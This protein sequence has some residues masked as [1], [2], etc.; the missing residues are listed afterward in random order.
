MHPFVNQEIA[1]Y[2]HADLLREAT[3]ARL[4]RTA[5]LDRHPRKRRLAAARLTWLLHFPRRRTAVAEPAANG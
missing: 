2:H 3:Q 4:A 5:R 1:R